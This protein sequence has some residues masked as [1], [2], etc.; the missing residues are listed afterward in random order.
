MTGSSRNSSVLNVSST[1]Q[2]TLST[3]TESLLSR[4][5]AVS[6]RAMCA[7]IGFVTYT[8]T[9]L[10]KLHRL[11]LITVLACNLLHHFIK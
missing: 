8:L 1:N 5:V 6:S 7:V 11:E 10:L 9:F 4:L 2:A 3:K